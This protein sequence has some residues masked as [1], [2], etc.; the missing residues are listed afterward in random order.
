ML[1]TTAEGGC[2]MKWAWWRVMGPEAMVM[3]C[4]TKEGYMG[5]DLKFSW[6]WIESQSGGGC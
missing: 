6:A 1:E 2:G 3:N 4:L 5:E